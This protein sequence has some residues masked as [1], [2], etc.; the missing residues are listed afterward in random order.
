MKAEDRKR[1]KSA[2]EALDNREFAGIC[3]GFQMTFGI[4]NPFMIVGRE[5]WTKYMVS[6]RA[7]DPGTSREMRDARLWKFFKEEGVIR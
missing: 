3:F 1:I 4:P 2:L 7:L 5:D 6:D